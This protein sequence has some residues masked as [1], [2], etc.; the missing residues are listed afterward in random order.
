MERLRCLRMT[1]LLGLAEGGGEDRAHGS[2]DAATQ[3]FSDAK[4]TSLGKVRGPTSGG[5]RNVLWGV[6]GV[7]RMGG[8]GMGDRGSNLELPSTV[9]AVQA[10]AGSFD[11]A[12]ASLRE[13]P[14]ALRMTTENRACGAVLRLD[15]STSLRASSRGLPSHTSHAV[16]LHRFH[17]V[18]GF[19]VGLVDS[20]AAGFLGAE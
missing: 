17:Q 16:A 7:K 14:A 13:T 6:G 12:C 19:A 15:P 2:P 8:L 1:R 10:D 5:R 9:W 3:R 4:T 11:F 18:P 20:L